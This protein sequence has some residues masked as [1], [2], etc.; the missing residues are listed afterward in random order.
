VG[1]VET[2]AP[3]SDRDV[4][5]VYDLV[6]TVEAA[7]G[8]PPVDP[9]WLTEAVRGS[10]AAGPPGLEAPPAAIAA[11][12]AWEPGGDGDTPAAYAH[13][14]RGKQRWEVELVVHPERRD[15]L[16]GVATPVLAAVLDAVRARGGGQAYLWVSRPTEADDRMARAAGFEPDRDLWQMVRPL[17]V[18]D[19]WSLAT[20][21][22]MAGKDEAGWVEVN[23]RAFDW[24]PEQG[25]WT[26]DDVLAREREPWFDPEGFLLHE[27]DGRLA[28]FCWTKVHDSHEPPLGEI[29]VI[30]VD[31]DF[32]G[33]GLG[34]ALTLAGLG[35]LADRG[36]TVG[37][38]YVDAGNIPAVRLYESL[39]FTVD[40]VDR[41]YAA[42]VPPA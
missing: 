20:R 4:A 40:H 26:V 17:P 37:M 33:L 25:G 1:Q 10:E 9:H 5:G 31:P 39:G 35:H 29:Y 36:L 14:S 28:G 2:R 30:A 13:V 3:L 41:A 24:H 19:T 18:E 23:N 15:D 27:R 22:F 6:R 7:T 32:T 11:F 34:R 38:L 21:P 42:D 16:S 8:Q 12:A